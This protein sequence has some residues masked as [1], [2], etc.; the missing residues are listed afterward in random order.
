[1][2]PFFALLTFLLA[3]VCAH[4]QDVRII[5]LKQEPATYSPKTFYIAAVTDSIQDS[6]GIGTINEGG[7]T[8]YIVLRDGTASA[9]KSFI[10]KSMPGDTTTQA[11]T[12]NIKKLNVQAK[13]KGVKWHINFSFRFLYTAGNVNLS[14]FSGSGQGETDGD[15]S[16]YIERRIRQSVQDNLS[17][18]EKWWVAQ[19]DNFPV[20]QSVKVNVT[21]GRVSDKKNLIVYSLQRPLQQAD[22]KG[23]VQENVPEK[24]MTLS[25]NVFATSSEVKSGQMVFGIEITPYFDKDQSW[26]NP[27]GA[28]TGLLAHEQAHF[29]ITAIKTCEL[30]NA[31]RSAAF[32]KDNYLTLFEQLHKQYLEAAN[33]QQN[34][35][36]TETNHGTIP[37]RQ[38]AWQEKIKQQVKDIGC[39]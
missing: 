30:V 35:Y 8:Q 28:N 3:A 19:K 24:A 16:A 5:Q 21:V 11:V 38:Q 15:P 9:I 6:T 1:M 25:G 7:K 2:K 4:A 31:L 10:D 39:Y 32:T 13:K 22:F 37:D 36:D 20:S 12:F 33:Q 34:T 18:F 29:D 27:N 26:F 23:E 17:R 14:E